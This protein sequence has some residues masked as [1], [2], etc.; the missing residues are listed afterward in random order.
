[1]TDLNVPLISTVRVQKHFGKNPGPFQNVKDPDHFIWEGLSHVTPMLMRKT[2]TGT[3]LSRRKSIV[4]QKN[5]YG[6]T[7]F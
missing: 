5:F 7:L 1:M 2:T 6:Q 4:L 3:S